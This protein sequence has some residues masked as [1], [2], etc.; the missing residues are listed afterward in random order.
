MSPTIGIT[1]FFVVLVFIGLAALVSGIFGIIGQEEDLVKGAGYVLTFVIIIFV[2]A[3]Q[4]KNEIIAKQADEFFATR[5]SVYEC[6]NQGP[7]Q[8]KYN[9]D[10]WQADSTAWAEALKEKGINYESND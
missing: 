6:K 5:E 7:V 8:Y 1:I 10:K 3:Y 9:I 2:T 4:Y